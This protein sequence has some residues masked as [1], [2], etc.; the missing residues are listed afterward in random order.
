[1]N[2]KNL[3]IGTK[4]LSGFILIA[5]FCGVVGYI[6]ITEINNVSQADTRMY[7]KI[8]VPLSQLQDITASFQRIRVNLRDYIYAVNI[9]DQKKFYDRIYEL[10]G[11]FK[12]DMEEFKK[13]L[14]TDEGK[15]IVSD[16][17]S[18]MADYMS[19]TEELK[20]NIVNEKQDLA[21]ELMKGEMLKANEAVQKNMDDIQS[22]K[23]KL[24]KETEAAN[25]NIASSASTFM[26]SIV[27]IS[28]ILALV[29][30]IIISLAITK[31]LAKGVKFA[32]ALAAGD[33]MSSLDIN[34]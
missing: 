27:I 11:V 29:I 8:T 4:L 23:V 7:E 19:H 3:K 17:E 18:N 10:Y 33:L 1:M 6:G 28:I 32:E 20:T 34:Q 26:I 21:I 5:L 13:T 12:K 31:P 9:D 22:L 25:S 14:L 30:G 24:A 16:L 2:F 15:K